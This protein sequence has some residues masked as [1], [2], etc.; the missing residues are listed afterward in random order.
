MTGG[1]N[2]SGKEKENINTTG[3]AVSLIV[4]FAIQV[5]IIL[6][7]SFIYD[8]FAPRDGGEILKKILLV[9]SDKTGFFYKGTL[10]VFTV[11]CTVVAMDVPALIF[12]ARRFSEKPFTRRPAHVVTMYLISIAVEGVALAILFYYFWGTEPFGVLTAIFRGIIGIV[13]LAIMNL[14][15][16]THLLPVDSILAIVCSI[17]LFFLAAPIIIIM[18]YRFLLIYIGIVCLYGLATGLSSG[19]INIV[20]VFVHRDWWW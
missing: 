11:L 12:L 5:G 3:I 7:M 18:Y 10:N 1:T 14:L 6:L 16:M 2:Q 15:I 20:Y 19:N 9:Q 8:L 17:V 4:L 13:Y